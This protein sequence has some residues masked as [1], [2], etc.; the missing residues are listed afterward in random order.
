V[1]ILWVSCMHGHGGVGQVERRV[2][3][4]GHSEVVEVVGQARPRW[5]ATMSAAGT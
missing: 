2:C 3:M 1:L 4:R 5:V